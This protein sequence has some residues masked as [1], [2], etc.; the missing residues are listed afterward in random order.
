MGRRPKTMDEDKPYKSGDQIHITV[1]QDFAETAT[2]FFRFC[3]RNHYSPSDVI[4]GGMVTWLTKTKRMVDQFESSDLSKEI[5]IEEILGDYPWLKGSL[6]LT[7][8]ETKKDTKKA[9]KK[10]TTKKTGK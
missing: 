1:T 2:D 6:N 8:K 3:K 7:A 4:R 5:I 10:T 9:T